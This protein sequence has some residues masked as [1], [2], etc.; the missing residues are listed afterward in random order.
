MIDKILD[1]FE[2]VLVYIKDVEALFESEND[3][4]IL[5]NAT[6]EF[7]RFTYLKQ[8]NLFILSQ[9]IEEFKNQEID[10]IDHNVFYQDSLDLIR[11][12]NFSIINNFT[13]PLIEKRLYRNSHSK[14]MNELKYR[15]NEDK[16]SNL[17]QL[18][19]DTKSQT[20]TKFNY[21]KSSVFV[22]L[23]LMFFHNNSFK[24][25]TETIN[26]DEMPLEKIKFFDSLYLGRPSLEKWIRFPTTEFLD[27]PAYQ[28]R[29]KAE[30]IE[31][32]QQKLFMIALQNELIGLLNSL[33]KGNRTLNYKRF[34]DLSESFINGNIS[35][36]DLK[37]FSSFIQFDR[38]A[39]VMIEL[40]N[41]LMEKEID[42]K[43][44]LPYDGPNKK[45][46]PRFTA[47]L[48]IL[49]GSECT[50]TLKLYVNKGAILD[51]NDTKY[52]FG[53]K[54]IPKHRV[55]SFQ[56]IHSPSN[57]AKFKAILNELN[58]KFHI[59]KLDN[60]VFKE[61]L[62]VLTCSDYT[63]LNILIHIECKTNLFSYILKELK[64]FFSNLTGKE[65]EDS[66][67]FFTKT[68]KKLL[69]AT[70]FNK[71]ANSKLI[72]KEEIRKI[73]NSK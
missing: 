20:K 59:I 23:D 17:L 6:I 53:K 24:N 21:L 64:P 65:I 14:Q 71:S 68:N 45:K 54:F 70:N 30:K 56:F 12:Y 57:L 72:E 44:Y 18:K 52:I 55:N 60:Q 8:G 13:L 31:K 63:K 38:S 7:G 11:K 34:L 51:L 41:I 67:L 1:R 42:Y 26:I 37:R 43:K 25:K 32:I 39:E 40:D 47:E 73:I 46:S 61:L 35:E 3:L 10:Y 22:Y 58:T 69:T 36:I 29:K 33:T 9:L 15:V 50:K 62:E 48:I 5:K 27:L 2:K 49:F 28:D 4:E 19:F 66:K 16:F